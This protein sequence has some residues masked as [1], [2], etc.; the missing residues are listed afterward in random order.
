MDNKHQAKKINS[1]NNVPQN[2]KTF[3][4]SKTS[5]ELNKSI[6]FLKLSS[7]KDKKMNTSN[8]ATIDFS[9]TVKTTKNSETPKSFKQFNKF[10]SL[11]T[12]QNKT[13]NPRE[14]KDFLSNGNLTKTITTVTID[15]DGIDE[16][17]R[18][19]K[20]ISPMHKKLYESSM[21]LEE[22]SLFYLFFIFLLIL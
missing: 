21:Q 14:Q 5:N 7:V 8:Y 4:N 17:R 13:R 20:E 2:Q 15:L 22:V 11:N 3:K 19:A 16:K 10:S 18:I 6:S 9:K 1:E 12:Q